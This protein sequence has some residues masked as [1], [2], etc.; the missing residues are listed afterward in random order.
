MSNSRFSIKRGRVVVGAAIVVALMGAQIDAARAEEPV[1]ASTTAGL[2]RVTLEDAEVQIKESL[3]AA[4]PGDALADLKEALGGEP[5]RANP[6]GVQWAVSDARGCARLVLRFEG[7]ANVL[8]LQ[9]YDIGSNDDGYFDCLDGA[10]RDSP[11][12]AST[13]ASLARVEH[14]PTNSGDDG[15]GTTILLIVGGLLAFAGLVIWLVIRSFY[16]KRRVWARFGA[17]HGLAVSGLEVNG[18]P[19]VSGTYRGVPIEVGLG[20]VG[21]LRLRGKG[22]FVVSDTRAVARLATPLPQGGDPA[23]HATVAAFL[24]NA[25]HA[26]VEADEVSATVAA[27]PGD[28]AALQ[29]L[30]DSC[31][32]V[33][34]AINAAR[35]RAS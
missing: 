18:E 10:R 3:A 7:G 35:A 11:G 9:R 4:S 19:R 15:R 32:D 2:T 6:D 24:A 23:V 28:V 27:M 12:T 33:A 29:Q 34:L 8:E 16:A 22:T 21:T 20:A 25:R 17:A 26:Y 30:V 14:E 1:A 31:V 13:A 5:V